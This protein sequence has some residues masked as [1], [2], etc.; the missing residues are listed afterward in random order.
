MWRGRVTMEISSPD[1]RNDN[2]QTSR[3]F[4]LMRQLGA[5]MMGESM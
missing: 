1:L 5:V 4:Y 3:R 2:G